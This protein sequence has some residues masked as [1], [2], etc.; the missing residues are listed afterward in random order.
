MNLV[1]VE[2]LTFKIHGKQA[3]PVLSVE[4][5]AEKWNKY[6][7]TMGAQGFGCSDI[8]NGGIVRSGKTIIAKIS[9]NGRVRDACGNEITA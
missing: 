3:V 9:Y 7:L 1:T 6:R 4:D 8:G 2:S 5:A